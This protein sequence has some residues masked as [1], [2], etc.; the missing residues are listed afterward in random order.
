MNGGINCHNFDAGGKATIDTLALHSNININGFGYRLNEYLFQT[1]KKT[2]HSGGCQLHNNGILFSRLDCKS[3]ELSFAKNGVLLD[4]ASMKCKINAINSDDRNTCISNIYRNNNNRNHDPNLEIYKLAIAVGDPN[5]K[6]EIASSAEYF[7]KFSLLHHN[8]S[9]LKLRDPFIIDTNTNNK[10]ERKHDLKFNDIRTSA[11]HPLPEE[12]DKKNSQNNWLFV[13]ITIFVLFDKDAGITSRI[14]I[15]SNGCHS[16]KSCKN[17]L[18]IDPLYATNSL[19]NK[20][21][22]EQSLRRIRK[23]WRAV[24]CLLHDA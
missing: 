11:Q 8:I 4:E 6:L 3:L 15:I 9:M 1:K 22:Q 24:A 23:L 20:V 17:I 12:T 7:G 10:N 21:T 16:N 5:F 18:I 14:G 2:V 13:D 19:K